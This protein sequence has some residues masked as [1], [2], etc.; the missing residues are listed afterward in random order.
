MK[1]RNNE[2]KR[3]P[4]HEFDT[5]PKQDRQYQQVYMN[6]LDNAQNDLS[7]IRDI[8]GE[9]NEDKLPQLVFELLKSDDRLTFAKAFLDLFETELVKY[10]VNKMD[11]FEY[12]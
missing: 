4:L 2:M 8:V 5:T 11:G 1:Q 3:I 6:E 9:M 12:D 7:T 10:G